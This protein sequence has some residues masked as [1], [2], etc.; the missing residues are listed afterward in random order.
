M[1]S[2]LCPFASLFFAPWVHFSPLRAQLE[3]QPHAHNLQ[4]V[5]CTCQLLFFICPD[6]SKHLPGAICV[7]FL[8]HYRS[9]G[10]S[11]PRTIAQKALE[12]LH[13]KP[14]PAECAERSAALVVDMARRVRLKAQKS[15]CQSQSADHKPPKNP[16]STPAHSARPPKSDRQA[17][18]MILQKQ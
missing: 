7:H 10:P 12:P 18:F 16:P 8:R 14:C 1:Q 6:C 13:K 3:T 17:D 4:F 5:R 15:E 2:L 11:R 9:V